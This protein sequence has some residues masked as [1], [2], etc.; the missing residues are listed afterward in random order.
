MAMVFQFQAIATTTITRRVDTGLD[1]ATA[2]GTEQG[3]GL[4]WSGIY[5][6][7]QN[8]TYTTETSGM[9]F[10]SL[11]IP[12]GAIINYAYLRIKSLNDNT[13]TGVHTILNG[14]AI[15]S[16]ASF[17]TRD[18]FMGRPRTSAA[19]EWDDIEPWSD[20]LYYTSPDLSAIVQEI[21]NRP[22][23][24]SNSALV[25]FWGDSGSTSADNAFRRGISCDGDSLHAPQLILN[26]GNG[27]VLSVGKASDGIGGAIPIAAQLVGGLSN[28]V[29][30]CR[31]K[32]LT[33]AGERYYTPMIWSAARS[34]FIGTI[35]PGSWFCK[36]CT[37]PTSGTYAVT[38]QIDSSS[39]FS[40]VDYADSS[41]TFSTFE[42][43][44][45]NSVDTQ[46]DFTDFIPTWN[47][48]AWD[49]VIDGLSVRAQNGTHCNTA[50]GIPFHPVTA[51]ITISSVTIDGNVVQPG[52][53]ESTV[54]A[55]W[56]DT[57]THTL[58]VQFDTLTTT[59][60]VI[61]VRFTS[62]TDL[63]ATRFD[64]KQTGKIGVRGFYNGLI[65]ANRYITA[66]TFGG[67]FEG[68]GEQVDV[69]GK[70][71]GA[72]G[73]QS[74]DCMERIGVVID[75]S[76]RMDTSGYYGANIKWN[77]NEWRTMLTSEDDNQ[78]T[79]TNRCDTTYLSGWKGYD[80]SRIYATKQH[81]YYAGKRF[82]RNDYR[83]QNRD[84]QSHELTFLCGKEQ[85]M[86]T[87]HDANDKG[88]Y[89]GDSTNRML[90]TK[91]AMASLPAP[92]FYA[93]D[94]LSYG[95]IGFIFLRSNQADSGYF[96]TVPP[97]HETGREWPIVVSNHHTMQNSN[98]FFTRYFGS[99]AVGQTKEFSFWV[100]AG[101]FAVSEGIAAIQTSIERDAIA[102]QGNPANLDCPG[103]SIA[104]L[105]F[106]EYGDS[107]IPDDSYISE[108]T[109]EECDVRYYTLTLPTRQQVAV[110]VCPTDNYPRPN[111]AVRNNGSCPGSTLLAC[112][113]PCSDGEYP[114]SQVRFT[115]EAGAQYWIIL[116]L[117][118]NHTTGGSYRLTACSDPTP[119]SLT[120]RGAG[121][122]VNL[123][124]TA[125]PGAAQYSIYRA[126]TFNVPIIPANLIGTSTTASFVDIGV[127]NTTASQYYYVVTSTVPS[128]AAGQP[129]PVSIVPDNPTMVPKK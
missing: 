69:R 87:D 83:L 106:T 59:Y 128:T 98:S 123:R 9:R 28:S 33:A 113:S 57:P 108:C 85:W 121:A 74:L 109:D 104:A 120:A 31:A 26:Y 46:F 39:S 79:I 42:T 29:F 10:D 1:D 89:A 51:A 64:R 103:V 71:A 48:A 117:E 92:Y 76:L 94:S 63:F 18:D 60:S 52:T 38:A 96:L 55:Y 125:V 47:G 11:T 12:P 23:W 110:T 75:D 17:T 129:Q 22:G 119:R 126:L 115:A 32:V 15:D 44:R 67:L 54:N 5:A 41:G 36:G 37:D 124:W 81:T 78:I 19:V 40:S 91:V 53:A 50:V 90:E 101:D 25:I 95:A 30:S 2:Y 66:E 20:P 7:Y 35:Y 56:W 112:G 111:L 114:G 77:R 70:E 14:Q 68:A 61:D 88:R 100:W 58:Y 27:V 49:Y 86:G 8:A 118:H 116:E 21:V 105:P 24:R 73:E 72:T 6:G 16:A 45:W 4:S 127:V 99:T 62:S 122:N 107:R 3:W 43:W 97:L 82:I 102:I 80:I 34:R 65:V 93:W 13:G 84:N